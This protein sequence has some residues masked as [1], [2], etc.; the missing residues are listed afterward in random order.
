VL[1]CT[2]RD[3]TTVLIVLTVR[4][5]Y[6]DVRIVAMVQEQEN[7]KLVRQRSTSATVMP[8]KVGGILL[9][10]SLTTSNLAAYVLDLITAG[11]R[12]SLIERDA[13]P[14]GRRAHTARCAYRP[15][16]QGAARRTSDRLPG[17]GHPHTDR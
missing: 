13:V 2:R 14:G 17:G 5:L 4:N 12:V 11:G 16:R 9:A 1:V 7:E 3:D 6:S 10:D 8:S 15:G